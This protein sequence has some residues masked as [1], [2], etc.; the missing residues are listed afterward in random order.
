VND[1]SE[2][3]QAY[4]GPALPE[5][6]APESVKT[7]ESFNAE[8]ADA[9]TPKNTGVQDKS[10]SG[11]TAAAVAL[12][13]G[14]VITS[15][16]SDYCNN[17]FRIRD[18]LKEQLFQHGQR[19]FGSMIDSKVAHTS[20]I[21]YFIQ[22]INRLLNLRQCKDP[23]GEEQAVSDSS[24]IASDPAS[25]QNDLAAL[26]GGDLID[27]PNTPAEDE[28]T[29][30]GMLDAVIQEVRLSDLPRAQKLDIVE[31]LGALKQRHAYIA[32]GQIDAEALQA[33][34]EDL[35]QFV[36]DLPENAASLVVGALAV[37][38]AA[39]TGFGNWFA[40]QLARSG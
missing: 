12:F 1:I 40:N 3:G 31:E 13:G 37:G 4:Y 28:L 29:L 2:T 20:S 24:H 16:N 18:D 33:F 19:D 6:D 14:L 30:T 15:D 10:S 17:L 22:F 25:G 36:Y 21:Q 23:P 35:E 5:V 7:D 11:G 8:V 34:S 9:A 26:V 39:V 38:W 32:Q 27:I